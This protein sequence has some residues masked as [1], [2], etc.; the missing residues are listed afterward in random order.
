[1]PPENR[2]LSAAYADWTRDFRRFTNTLESLHIP[3]RISAPSGDRGAPG[4]GYRVEATYC[5]ETRPTPAAAARKSTQSSA[6]RATLTEHSVGDLGTVAV[7]AASDDELAHYFPT[8][9]EGLNDIH[10]DIAR[11]I[12]IGDSR[13]AVAFPG[14]ILYDERQRT[15]MPDRG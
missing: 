9:P 12:G 3:V 5:V 1:L 15:L 2:A 13:P 14:T 10:R 8:R 7:T 4:A 11:A 6:S